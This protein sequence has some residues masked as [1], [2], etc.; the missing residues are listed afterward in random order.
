MVRKQRR[1]DEH[2]TQ[3]GDHRVKFGSLF[4]GIGGIDS[5]LERAGMTCA[6]QVEI[7]PF[8]QD[9]LSKHWPTVRRFADVTLVNP[10]TLPKVAVLAAGFPCQDT[11]RA[12]N[13]GAKSIN[14]K[15]SGLFYEVTRIARAMGRPILLLENSPALLVRGFGDVLG[16]LAASG[17]D[18]R[19]D[20]VPAGAFGAH[21]ERDRLFIF[22]WP[23]SYADRF[24]IR[25]ESERRPWAGWQVRKAIGKHAEPL[26]AGDID[27]WQARPGLLRVDDGIPETLDRDRFRAIGN[28]VSPVVAEY[29]GRMIINA[30]KGHKNESKR[31]NRD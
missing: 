24:A 14:G 2:E 1:N 30:M 15:R 17:Y 9:V 31:K 7:D 25:F 12:N 5:G 3:T 21:H 28:S 11:S 27:G 6:F 29:L 18:A 4:S 13:H 10:A 22:A 19:W 23:T 26:D 8:C 20:C 16:E